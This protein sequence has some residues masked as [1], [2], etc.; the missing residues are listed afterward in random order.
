L[1]GGRR[2]EVFDI[3][4]MAFAAT[5]DFSNAVICAQNALTFATA[6]NLKDTQPIRQRLELYQQHRPWRESFRAT[7]APARN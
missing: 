7:N 1:S 2:P 5:G 3:L 6:A 4:G